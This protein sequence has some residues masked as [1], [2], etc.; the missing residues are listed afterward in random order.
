[1]TNIELQSTTARMG[2]GSSS[3][4]QDYQSIAAVPIEEANR[5][6]Q[7]SQQSLGSIKSRLNA[8]FH[9]FIRS[10]TVTDLVVSTI[11]C[12]GHMLWFSCFRTSAFCYLMTDL[13]TKYIPC[14]R[15]ACQ[16]PKPCG[17]N[18]RFRPH[19]ALFKL[20]LLALLFYVVFLLIN[21]TN[22]AVTG[23]FALTLPC[24]LSLTSCRTNFLICNEVRNISQDDFLFINYLLSKSYVRIEDGNLLTLPINPKVINMSGMT[25][26]AMP[27]TNSINTSINKTSALKGK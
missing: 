23:R 19:I 18:D 7:T 25:P 27:F 21:I 8:I 6:D 2:S 4:E 16:F 24:I 5:A 26:F 14:M 12:L 20:G 15:D 11:V 1:M 9:L 17:G 10:K 22:L 3:S 13:P